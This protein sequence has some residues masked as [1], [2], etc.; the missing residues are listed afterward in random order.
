[1]KINNIQVNTRKDCQK[2]KM[3]SDPDK[4]MLAQAM[5]RSDWSKVEEEL[6]DDKRLGDKITDKELP[7]RANLVCSMHIFTI[8]RNTST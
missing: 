5:Q 8:Q 7:K 4:F 3:K 6:T 1:M 2:E